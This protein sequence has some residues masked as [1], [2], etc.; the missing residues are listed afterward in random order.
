MTRLITL[1]FLSLVA[2]SSINLVAASSIN[3]PE[4]FGTNQKSDKLLM[5]N[6]IGYH[7]KKVVKEVSQELFVSRKIDVSSLFMGLRVLDQTHQDLHIYCT[8]ITMREKPV[9]VPPVMASTSNVIPASIAPTLKPRYIH[10]EYPAL[11]SYRESKARCTAL[12]M[13]LPEIYSLSQANELSTFMKKHKVTKCFAGLEPDISDATFRFVATGFPIW[14]TPHADVVNINGKNHSIVVKMDD[15][16][17]KWL[18]GDDSK[19]YYMDSHPSIQTVSKI[20]DHQYRDKNK[21]FTQ[22]VGP[23][24]CE[25][26]WSGEDLGYFTSNSRKIQ[27]VDITSYDANGNKV[28]RSAENRS[29]S[30]LPPDEMEDE[31]TLRPIPDNGRHSR[32]QPKEV[33][34]LKEYCTSVSIQALDT[35]TEMMLKLQELLSLAD[36]SFHMENDGNRDKRSALLKGRRVRRSLGRL[37]RQKRFFLAKIAFKMGFN[38]IWNLFGFAQKVSDYREQRKMKQG[39][40]ANKKQSAENREAIQEMSKIILNHSISIEQLRIT[41]ANLERRINTLEV[42]VDNIES[43]V[44]NITRKVDMIVEISLISNLVSRIQ[45]SMN[46]GYNVLKDIIHSSLLGQTSPLLLPLD[47][48]TLVQN[49]VMKETSGVLDSDFIRMQSLVVSDPSNPSVLLVVVNVAATSRKAVELV[50]LV[51]IPSYENGKTFVPVLDY[52]SVVLDRASQTYSIL[53]EQ[54]EQDCLNSRCYVQDTER[55]IS[56]KACGIPQFYDQQESTCLYVETQSNGIFMKSMLPDGILF[57]FKTEVSSQMFCNENKDIGNMRKLTGMGTM[58]L[59]NGCT[60]TVTNKAGHNAKIKGPAMYRMIAADD[61][62]LV[63]NGPLGTIRTGVGDSNTNKVS[64]YEGMLA[65]QLDPV[66]TQMTNANVRITKTHT[67]M[68]ILVGVAIFTIVVVAIVAIFYCRHYFK[69]FAKIYALRAKVGDLIQQVLALTNA[70]ERVRHLGNRISAMNPLPRLPRTIF[71]N[72]ILSHL[73]NRRRPLQTDVN[74]HTTSSPIPPSAYVSMHELNADP[75]RER[76][77][78]RFKPIPEHESNTT[79]NYSRH[80]LPRHY[81]RLSPM[82][83]EMQDKGHEMDNDELDR[84]SSEVEEFCSKEPFPPDHRTNP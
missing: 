73:Q 81:P 40:A 77:Y 12:H 60:L 63:L 55:S 8:R 48:M 35:K 37:R 50:K 29:R 49:E 6:H 44:S 4:L 5:K 46:S 18:Y 33:D 79:N 3:G 38:L 23:I 71:G 59:P 13:Q 66:I 27:E 2:T 47:Q 83:A 39:I 78:V 7:F 34:V 84:E 45:Q 21:A 74:A 19:L 16:Y 54:E 10:V 24:I 43:T 36:I 22:T 30:D 56:Q 41:T 82:L 52:S 68:W 20:G 15:F 58:Q 70:R 31:V 32:A 62:T 11:A 17:T 28:K 42:K 53:T 75:R 51:P 69:I 76:T 25:K 65:T 57:A 9:I 67:F 61:L 64:T 26:K 14:R 80:T 72:N 1:M